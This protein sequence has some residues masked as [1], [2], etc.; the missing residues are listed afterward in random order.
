LSQPLRVL[1]ELISTLPMNV[2]L[3]HGLYE[4]NEQLQSAIP[5]HPI[6]S[7]R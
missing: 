6:W 1:L 7:T 3:N 2:K 4:P 5:W